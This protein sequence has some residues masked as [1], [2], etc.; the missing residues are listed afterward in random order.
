[1]GVVT[2]IGVASKMKFQNV[3]ILSAVLYTSL[4]VSSP[5]DKEREGNGNIQERLRKVKESLDLGKGPADQQEY[6]RYWSELMANNP[7]TLYIY[8]Y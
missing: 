6:A 2:K 1:M 7:G 5:L 3:I 4:S 8:I